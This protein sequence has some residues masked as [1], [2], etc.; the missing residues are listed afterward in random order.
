MI[1]KGKKFHFLSFK[2]KNSIKEIKT[3]NS[4]SD[5]EL[6]KICDFVQSD[7]RNL[8]KYNKFY[9]NCKEETNNFKPSKDTKT[10]NFIKKENYLQIPGW[11]YSLPLSFMELAVYSIIYGFTQFVE[12]Q[13]FYGKRSYIAQWI[14]A[15]ISTVQRIL[16]GLVEKGYLER[17]YEIRNGKLIAKY[18]A[19]E[20][21]EK[22]D[23]FSEEDFDDYSEENFDDSFE[24]EA[25]EKSN[26]YQKT[27]EIKKECQFDHV[28]Q[29][30]THDNTSILDINNI[31]N[32]NIN[33]LFKEKENNKRK[34]KEPFSLGEFEFEFEKIWNEYPRKEKKVRAKKSF[35]KK[36]KSGIKLDVLFDGLRKHKQLWT[37]RKIEQKYIPHLSN[38]LNDERWEDE[39]VQKYE[40]NNSSYNLDEY[41]SVM[42]TFAPTPE[43]IA[44]FKKTETRASFEDFKESKREE[45][46][47]KYG[48]RI[49]KMF[50]R[51]SD[52]EEF[53]EG[54]KLYDENIKSGDL[55]WQNGNLFWKDK[56]GH[57]EKTSEN[58]ENSFETIFTVPSFHDRYP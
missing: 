15:S 43:E 24:E 13:W 5:S 1:K 30:D 37:Q 46:V 17:E 19:V 16:N 7:N 47:R 50:M 41:E 6:Y 51:A 14:K 36:I 2:Q 53:Q 26:F 8:K 20:I 4:N 33:N 27:P 52:M 42:D 22:F 3:I 40:F 54:I 21:K 55:V 9:K 23:D 58:N 31:N 35:F 38:W 12:G 39:C 32:L 49:A 48:F 57:E 45:L 10:F 56:L 34:R 28:C 25:T 11:A 44:S 18:R 29:I